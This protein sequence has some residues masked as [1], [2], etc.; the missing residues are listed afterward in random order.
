MKRKWT[1]WIVVHCSAT[2]ASMDIGV[3]RIDSWH[4]DRG[5]SGCGYHYVIRRDGTVECGRELYSTGAHVRGHNHHAL[6]ICLVGG[7]AEDGG[8]E[9]NFT[10]GQY[11]ALAPLLYQLVK[12][13]PD[14]D[15]TGHRNFPNVNKACPC[16][17]AA[18]WWAQQ[19]ENPDC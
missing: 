17:D 4:R 9:D 19:D 14:A 2:P 8:P 12:L 10:P 13:F 15:V 16:F 11:E 6:G 5:W 3:D 7:V 18:S 1:D